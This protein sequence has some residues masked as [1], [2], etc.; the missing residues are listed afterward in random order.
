MG[1]N[2][3]KG[4]GKKVKQRGTATVGKKKKNLSKRGNRRNSTT[5]GH[6]GTQ[7]RQKEGGDRREGR[8][9]NLGSGSVPAAKMGSWA[10]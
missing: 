3:V 9:K 10:K 7:E 1:Q 2:W 4:G 8:K 5:K 6:P